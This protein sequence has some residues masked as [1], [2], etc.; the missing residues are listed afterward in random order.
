[1]RRTSIVTFCNSEIYTTYY[2]LF[3]TS[4]SVKYCKLVYLQVFTLKSL[5][6]PEGLARLNYKVVT[7]KTLIVILCFLGS[8]FTVKNSG[9]NFGEHELKKEIIKLSEQKQQYFSR[10]FNYYWVGRDTSD[11]NFRLYERRADSTFFLNCEHYQEVKFVRLLDS[12]EHVL[13]EIGKDFN[14]SKLQS[15]TFEQT[16]LYLDLDVALSNE[17]KQKFGSKVVTYDELKEFF[18][19]SSVTTQFN[20]FMKPFKKKVKYYSMEK[21]HLSPKERYKKF[22]TQQEFDNYPEYA[23]TGS[24]LTVYIEDI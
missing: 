2:C 16:E 12:L 17:Y 11:L 21:F 6:K 23:V 20:L 7:M 24:D 3:F 5:G 4:T 10:A 9:K 13:P 14:L 15:I 8:L 19:E 18:I 1:M 22:K